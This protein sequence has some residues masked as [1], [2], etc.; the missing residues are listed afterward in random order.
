M[1][2]ALEYIEDMLADKEIFSIWLKDVLKMKG[3]A[4]GK[5]LAQDVGVAPG[6]ISGWFGTKSKGPEPDV[7]KRI[8]E[9]LTNKYEFPSDYDEIIETGR[10]ESQ[11]QTQDIDKK[12]QEAV[13]K[14]VTAVM[15]AQLPTVAI[16]A[17]ARPQND[18][19][20][21]KAQKNQPH[22][23]L[24]NKFRHPEL[25]FQLNEKIYEIEGLSQ[26]AMEDIDDYLDNKL[27]RLRKKKA[28][29]EDTQGNKMG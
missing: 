16:E 15:E 25:A 2:V 29:G 4:K 5:D 22:H 7:C 19:E 9:V 21:R 20:R 13:D 8:C 3:I 28:P 10:Q 1:C 12:I 11:P 26:D 24:V 14:K 17:P 18:I 27:K 23:D 6:T